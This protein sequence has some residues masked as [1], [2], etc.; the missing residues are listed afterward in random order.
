MTSL[1]TWALGLHVVPAAEALGHPRQVAIA[2]GA[3]AAQLR[4][5][6]VCSMGR[7]RKGRA[8]GLVTNVE[9]EAGVHPDRQLDDGRWKR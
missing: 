2:A 3:V 6:G 1:V 4:S 5:L 7:W 9:R 8:E